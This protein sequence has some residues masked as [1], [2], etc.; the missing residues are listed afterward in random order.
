[1]NDQSST[2]QTESAPQQ[3][4]TQ[5]SNEVSN[6][7]ESSGF[8]AA[9]WDGSPDSLSDSNRK[10]YD[11]IQE[12]NKSSEEQ[13]AGRRLSEYLDR[14]LEET[15]RPGPSFETE[16]GD[17]NLTREE[18]MRMWQ[19]QDSDRKRNDMIDKFRKSMLDVVGTPQNFGNS[20]VAFASEQEVDGFREF[21]SKTLNGGL[22]ARDLLLLY[23]Q[24]A[25]LK[26]HGDASIRGF[27]TSLKNRRPTD[28]EGDNVVDATSSIPQNERRSRPGRAPRTAE[29]L[30]QNNPE[31]YNAILNGKRDLI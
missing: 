1:M 13:T 20:T 7:T 24:E 6:A 2:P 11:A 8:D 22:S 28:V 16:G 18:A 14:K 25:I 23:R 5:Q 27:E 4:A 26:Q 19:Q 30:Q 10:F 15:R 21:V 12:R 9:N 17:E 3:S 31:L 29:I